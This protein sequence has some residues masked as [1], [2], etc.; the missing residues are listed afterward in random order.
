MVHSN[1]SANFTWRALA[2]MFAVVQLCSAAVQ[3]DTRGGAASLSRP[4]ICGAVA[5]SLDRISSR[6]HSA[7]DGSISKVGGEPCPEVEPESGLVDASVG[8]MIGQS[9]GKSGGADRAGAVLGSVAVPVKRTAFDARWAR[10]E[11]AG[12]AGLMRGALAQAGVSE[13]MNEAQSINRVNRWVNQQIQYRSDQQLYQQ[14]DYWATAAE[15][16]ANKAGDCEDY[17][18]LKMQM[19]RAAGVSPTRLKLML[20][21]DLA[22]NA[23]HAFLLV[24]GASEDQILDNLVDRVVAARD[25]ASVRPILSFSG[26]RRWLHAMPDRG[27]MLAKVGQG[28]ELGVA[29]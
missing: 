18:V 6:Q 9:R 11:A 4:A 17:A 24:A 25:M 1:F 2:T 22:A 8:A 14:K 19:L 29:G 15:T 7:A 16:L 5:S 13:G 23:D 26:N 21:R 3:A 20:L 28:V 12:S 10:V 27:T